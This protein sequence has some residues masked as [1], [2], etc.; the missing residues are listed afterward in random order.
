M[1]KNEQVKTKKGQLM[2]PLLV[3]TYTCFPTT[4]DHFP[5]WRMLSFYFCCLFCCFRS[6]VNSSQVNKDRRNYFKINLHKSMGKG[7][8]PTRDPWTIFL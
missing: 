5:Q 2:S 8:D 4:Y 1:W 6:Q 3:Q 7:R